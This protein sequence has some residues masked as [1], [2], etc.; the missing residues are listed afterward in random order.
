DI[1]SKSNQN[2]FK[3]L[4]N[5]L[6]AGLVVFLVAIP[7]CLGI[8][9]VLGVPAFS[10]LI[11]GIVGGIVVGAFSN[12]RI[13]VSGPAA[14]LIAIII[15]AL[16]SFRTELGADGV[17]EADIDLMALQMLGFSVLIAGVIQLILG[18]LKA[19]FIGYYFPNV[20]IKGM[21]AAIGLILI[22]K[23]LTHG[24]GYD[25]DALGNFFN[26]G[27]EKISFFQEMKAIILN[28][29]E[30]SL[31]IIL[32]TITSLA[33][34]IIWESKFIK[35]TVLRFA[36]GAVLVVALG[37]LYTFFMNGT[38]Y[39]IGEEHRVSL[40][41]AGKQFSELFAFPLFDKVGSS[42]IWITGATIAIVA[43][44]ETLLCVEATDKLDPE[45]HVTN[46]NRELVAQGIGNTIAGFLGGLPITQ[47]IV[48]SSANINSGAKTK[49]S[50]IFHGI[51]IVGFIV[52]LPSVLNMIPYASL[53]AILFM[54]GYKLAKPSLFR[55]I[56]KK[57]WAEFIP[58]V[59]TIVG[60]LMTDLLKGI[61]IGLVFSIF[62]I[63]YN[64]FKHSHYL[65]KDTNGEKDLYRVLLSEN[66]TFLNKASLTAELDSIPED[67]K[68]VLDYSSVKHLSNDIKE[69][70]EEFRMRA[71]NEDIEVETINEDYTALNNA[72]TA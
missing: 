60:I 70:L 29:S 14:G 44:I 16:A 38:E 63:L 35:K 30:M 1:M 42:S 54:V 11:A 2:I 39:G 58:F 52:L 20:V 22:K 31:T 7:L 36:P 18:L 10:G 69:I 67:V 72:A 40:G 61:G 26:L 71:E 66:M 45:K 25:K 4:K 53:A 37:I 27:D 41:I 13:G 6:H 68:V 15:T 17:A 21:L 23:E 65:Q 3:H 12:S 56:Y 62:F 55:A 43:S 24:L 46:P 19:G 49:M 9:L 32:I 57:G 51:L 28:P 64:N 33:I 59:A 5:D 34:L 8:A 47:V 50:A 48:R